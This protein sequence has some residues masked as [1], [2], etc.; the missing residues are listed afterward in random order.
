MTTVYC[1]GG[2]CG[3]TRLTCYC[4]VH[5]GLTTLTCYCGVHCGLT[6]L[7]SLWSSLWSDLLLWWS[8]WSDQTDLLLWWSLWSDHTDF[9]VVFT[10]VWPYW[11]ATT[12]WQTF[13]GVYIS[14]RS[15]V[16]VQCFKLS[17]SCICP[18]QENCTYHHKKLLKPGLMITASTVHARVHPPNN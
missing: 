10:V 1:C 14:Q 13:R 15:Q 17:N 7:T 16:S 12:I 18:S 8:L 4:G 2:H 9:T 5:C 3:L 11:P 6:T